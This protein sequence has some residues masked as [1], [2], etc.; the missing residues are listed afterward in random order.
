MGIT[1]NR[2]DIPYGRKNAISR[3]TL[4]KMWHC[5][6]R[7]AREIIAYLR[8]NPGDDGCAILS[9]SSTTPAGYWRSDDQAEIQAFIRETENRARNTFLSLKDAKRVLRMQNN[10]GQVSIDEISAGG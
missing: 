7:T 4:R 3:L 9:T 6:D 2:F 5:D 1:A 10:S 8:R